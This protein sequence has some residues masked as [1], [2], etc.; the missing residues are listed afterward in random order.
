MEEIFIKTKE[1]ENELLIE[2]TRLEKINEKLSKLMETCPHELV[3]KYNDNHP[4]KRVI[5][6]HYFCPACGKIIICFNSNQLNETDFKNSRVISLMDISIQGTKRT[7]NIIKKEVSKNLNLYY[8]S[9]VDDSV[10]A[11]LMKHKLE[12]EEYD[13]YSS[14]EFIKKSK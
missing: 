10:L 13:Y 14:K 7:L 2:Q 9:N 3:F 4:R 5:D 12:K 1:L 11:L 8:H 6:G